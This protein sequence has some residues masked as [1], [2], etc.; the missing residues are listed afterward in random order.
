MYCSLQPLSAAD[1]LELCRHFHTIFVQDIPKMTIRMR[2]EARR[3]ITFIDT[4]YEY[5]V[6]GQPM[7]LVSCNWLVS[8]SYAPGTLV[9]LELC[10]WYVGYLELCTW[11]V[12]CLEL[13]TWYVGFL[14]LCTWMT[15][16]SRM[17]RRL[18]SPWC[19][20]ISLSIQYRFNFSF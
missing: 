1:Y 12:G 14:E 4:L 6:C 9:T 20:L 17:V 19:Q 16:E 13:C 18:V 10:T 7:H 2:P 11:Y 5:K 8:W 3:F 15:W